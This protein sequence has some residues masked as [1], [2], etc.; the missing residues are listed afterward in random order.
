[1]VLITVVFFL[2]HLNHSHLVTV[3][4]MFLKIPYKTISLYLLFV[5][6]FLMRLRLIPRLSL[7][8]LHYL[9]FSFLS[10]SVSP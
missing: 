6:I 4:V 2:R 10:G 7:W 5:R 3:T 8:E 1:M 9:F